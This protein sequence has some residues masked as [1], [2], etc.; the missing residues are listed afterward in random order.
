VGGRGVHT[1]GP[2]KRIYKGKVVET[3]SGGLPTVSGGRVC[4]PFDSKSDLQ[5]HVVEARRRAS[6]VSGGRGMHD[7][8]IQK[9]DFQRR[10]SRTRSEPPT[11]SWGGRARQW[12]PKRSSRGSSRNQERASHVKWGEGMHA[13]DSKSDLQGDVVEARKRASHVSGGE[14][15]FAIP[16]PH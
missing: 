16:P 2:P 8:K 10:S 9:A 3:R 15:S 5:G 13:M 12:I 11:S 4:T 7:M 14:E 1:M 6:H